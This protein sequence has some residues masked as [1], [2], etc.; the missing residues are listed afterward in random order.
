MYTMGMR[1]KTSKWVNSYHRIIDDMKD[2]IQQFDILNDQQAQT[3][4]RLKSKDNGTQNIIN[5]YKTNDTN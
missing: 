4:D 2:V 5:T 3:Q 1:L